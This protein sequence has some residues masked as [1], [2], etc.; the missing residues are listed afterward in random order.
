MKIK[1]AVDKD[2]LV[3]LAVFFGLGLLWIMLGWPGQEDANSPVVR[4]NADET[5]SSRDG[6]SE[7]SRSATGRSARAERLLKAESPQVV[8]DGYTYTKSPWYKLVIIGRGTAKSADEARKEYI[9]LRADSHNEQPINIGNWKLE[10]GRNRRPVQ[11]SSFKEKTLSAVRVNIPLATNL[12]VGL[13]S[14]LQPVVLGPGDRAYIITGSLRT[15]GDLPVRVSFRTNKC[16][17]YLADNERNSFIPS[18]KKDCPRPGDEPGVENLTDSCYDF[19]RRLPTCHIPDDKPF[20]DRDGDLVRNHLD[21]NVEL[22]K[23]CRDWVKVRFSYEACVSRHI[24]DED[25][26]GTEWR[27]YLN[28][29]WELWNDRREVITLYDDQ[30]LL[31]DQISY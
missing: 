17:G 22:S 31:V 13:K 11:I 2:L 1:G 3:F 10:N 16:I 14:K 8:I 26:Y 4:F 15:G 23:I 21:G 28:R 24:T 30:G 18:L 29:D 5:D 12:F 27:V 25:F 20:R 19:V 9:E 7:N 6:N